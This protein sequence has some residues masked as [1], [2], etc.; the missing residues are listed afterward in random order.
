VNEPAAAPP[1]L[2]ARF[3]AYLALLAKWQKAVNLVSAATLPEARMR[4][5]E[6]SLQLAPHIPAQTKTLADLGS[7]AGF[8]GLVLAM[9]RPEL[10]VHL[11]ESDQKKGSF[12]AAVSRETHTP[13]TLHRARLEK[14]VADPAVP[15]PDVVTARAFAALADI[16]AYCLP[17][18][19][20]N[21]ALVFLLPK[22]AQAES[23]ID[24]AAAQFT[25]TCARFPSR[26]DPKA[27][28][29]KLTELRRKV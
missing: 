18:A 27:Q 26:T 23:E 21:P 4:H 22:G 9:A 6:D 13:V 19:E 2:E 7:G 11:I 16:L 8:P 1:E 5:I 24:A 12:L 20:R 14:V 15:V 28:L 17:W 29:L 10:A 3:A 25:F